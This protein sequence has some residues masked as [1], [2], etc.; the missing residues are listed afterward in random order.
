MTPRAAGYPS[1]ANVAKVAK[2][3]DAAN[4]AARA[5]T[6]V[7][8]RAEMALGLYAEA[9]DRLERAVDKA[10]ADLP[11]RQALCE[12]FAQLGDRAALAAYVELHL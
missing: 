10:P 1:V 8:A 12:L 6:V 9:R 4:S 3:A 5:G 7:A 11:L 2:V